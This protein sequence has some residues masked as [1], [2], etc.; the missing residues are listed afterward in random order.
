MECAT[1][2]YMPL[3][4]NKCQPGNISID[5]ITQW[6]SILTTFS[7]EDQLFRSK[8]LNYLSN[9]QTTH[10]EAVLNLNKSIVSK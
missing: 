4:A 3:S 7:V 1:I 10:Q 9:R 5:S 6:C 8:I 2:I